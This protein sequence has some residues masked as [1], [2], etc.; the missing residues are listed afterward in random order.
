MLWWIAAALAAPLTLTEVLDAVDERVPELAAADAKLREA[1]GKALASRGAFDP[2][3]S[4]YGVAVT[5]PYDRDTL[6]LGLGGETALGPTW[7]AGWAV[8]SGDF[9]SYDDGET[10][11]GGEW[12][13]GLELPLLDG[14]VWSEARTARDVALA[15]AD[16]AD[17]ELAAKRVAARFGAGSAWAKWVAAGQKRDVDADLL[18]LALRRDAGLR[19][20]VEEGTRAPVTL[21]DNQRI[22]L[23]RSDQLAASEAAVVVA[24]RKLGLYLRAPD[25]SPAPPPSDR[26]PEAWP[27]PRPMPDPELDVATV[28]ARPDL[29]ALDAAIDAA[30]RER[31]R[32]RNA[33]LPDLDVV[34]GAAVPVAGSEAELKGGVKLSSPVLLRK[35]RGSLAAADAALDGLT[36]VR[37]GTLDAAHAALAAARAEHDA[38]EQR[39]ALATEA[40]ERAQ[41]LLILER[42]RFELGDADLFALWQREEVVGKARKAA[43][44]AELALRSA[45]LAVEAALG[46]SELPSG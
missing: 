25:G 14:L 6:W 17:A 45:E 30:R 39:V 18:D 7:T 28:A 46:R 5:G 35:E 27:A 13:V 23:E 24:A 9:P 33:V 44:E 40:A 19:R 22:V 3:A 42:R 31:S 1:E 2:K 29:R 37:R 36:Q 21:I 11:A 26:L 38:A 32:A 34:L 12:Q 15:K 8:G 10:Y 16:R 4:G 20:E 43:I 41:E